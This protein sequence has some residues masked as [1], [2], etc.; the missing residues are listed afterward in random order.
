M[1]NKNPPDYEE[2]IEE[3]EK[4]EVVEAK[5]EKASKIVAKKPAQEQ[6]IEEASEKRL[7]KLPYARER[8]QF[9][10]LLMSNPNYFGNLKVSPFEPVLSIKTNT[11]ES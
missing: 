8:A 6:P 11:T 4:A 10:A 9:R 7:K 1:E 3:T 5:V 2:E